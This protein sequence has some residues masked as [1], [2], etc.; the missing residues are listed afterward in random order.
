MFTDPQHQID[1]CKHQ[2]AS[3]LLFSC[4]FISKFKYAKVKSPLK[5]MF[6]TQKF[7]KATSLWQIIPLL[8]RTVKIRKL[9]LLEFSGQAHK[10]L[11]HRLPLLKRFLHRVQLKFPSN[12]Q[13]KFF[14]VNRMLNAVCNVTRS[15]L[16]G[17][18]IQQLKK[19]QL[20]ESKEQ[21]QG[22]EFFFP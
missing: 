19:L 1:H 9:W 5:W 22:S 20:S 21:T 15:P 3:Q 13:S 8:N 4:S 18:V 12:R 2:R 6:P 10:T 17:N 11:H 16:D 7:L 14:P